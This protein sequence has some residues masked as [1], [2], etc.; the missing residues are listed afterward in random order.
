MGEPKQKK[1]RVG[2][3]RGLSD[4]GLYTGEVREDAARQMP[5]TGNHF[6]DVYK[7]FHQRARP[8]LANYV[9]CNYCCSGKIG[10]VDDWQFHFAGGLTFRFL[11][12]YAL[13]MR[14]TNSRGAAKEGEPRSATA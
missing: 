8:D 14:Y 12:F 4:A 10:T 3:K 5:V 13:H 9:F 7:H 11:C 1:Q 2:R 6:A